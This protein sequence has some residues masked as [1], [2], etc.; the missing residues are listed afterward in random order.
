MK[1]MITVILAGVLATTL[2]G[3]STGAPAVTPQPEPTQEV[4]QEQNAE[5][6]QGEAAPPDAQKTTNIFGKVKNIVGNEIE[7]E[8]ANPPFEMGE[9]DAGT[10]EGASIAMTPA[11]TVMVDEEALP[12]GAD[13]DGDG[14]ITISVAD[15]DGS[16][17]VVDGASGGNKMELNYTGETKSVIIP[18]GIDIM[19]VL[20]GK[21]AKLEDI[22]KGSVLLLTVDDAQAERM[23]AQNI[24]IME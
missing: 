11:T 6:E 15:G 20:T 4:A 23:N 14:E 13:S 5:G 2:W 22:K 8:L 3:C 12:E 19:S 10:E 7:L 1:K 16:V 17:N 21:S 9:P 24:T 18:T